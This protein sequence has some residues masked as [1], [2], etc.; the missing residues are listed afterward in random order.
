VAVGPDELQ[1]SRQGGSPGSVVFLQIMSIWFAWHPEKERSHQHKHGV[2]FE[3]AV[4]V[5][6]DPL[7]R[8]HQDPEHPRRERREIII[9]HS[10]RGRL[11]LDSFT[12]RRGS[13]RIISARQATRHERKDYEEGSRV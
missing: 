11:L 13:T 5:F 8:I 12:E 4:T 3:E 7:A 2:S 9:G 1:E 10:S 6:G